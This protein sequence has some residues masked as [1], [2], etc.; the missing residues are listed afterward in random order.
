MKTKQKNM[1]LP[2]LFFFLY[3]TGLLENLH[4]QQ[5]ETKSSLINMFI[6]KLDPQMS[7]FL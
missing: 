6:P 2:F 7:A 1:T 5:F 3:T 4:Q